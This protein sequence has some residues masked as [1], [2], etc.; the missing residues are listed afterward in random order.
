VGVE[1]S[2][3]FQRARA[4]RFPVWSR[5]ERNGE[6]PPTSRKRIEDLEDHISITAYYQGELEDERT[7]HYDELEDL[8]RQW[9][10]IEGWQTF[11]TGRTDASIDQAKA[12]LNPGLW[13]QI[14]AKRYLIARL[15]EQIDRME[16]D[17]TKASRI[18][19]LLTGS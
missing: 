12:Q 10:G 16:R 17:A 19:T 18:Y 6:P 13:R 14:K 11:R 7:E 3:A 15:C 1:H 2:D 8:L 9:D 4:L 5:T